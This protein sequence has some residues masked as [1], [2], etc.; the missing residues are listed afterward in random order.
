M[1]EKN[2][3]FKSPNYKTRPK[4]TIIDTIIIHFTDM[5]DD[6][7][8]LNKLCDKKAEVSSHYL[9]SKDGIIFSL[10]AEELCAWHAGKSY[11]QGREALN[12]FS[13]GIELDNN[14]YEDFTETQ[15]TSLISLCKEIIK[16]HPINPL[17]VLGHSDVAPARK[18]DPGR[19]FNWEFLAKNGIGIYPENVKITEVLD[20]KETQLMLAKYGYKIFPTEIIDKQ[21][22]DIMRAFNEHFN[23]TCYNVWS[24]KSQEKLISLLNYLPK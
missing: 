18:F 10:V 24:Q 17:F 11:W 8:A 3:K 5:K 7:T 23:P 1:I 16:S 20:L 22:I 14:G 12:N 13:I 21:T 15:M 4:D 9:I 6:I 19:L 2:Y